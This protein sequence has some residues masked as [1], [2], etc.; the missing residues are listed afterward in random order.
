MSNQ[1]SDLKKALMSVIDGYKAAIDK[2]EAVIHKLEAL[3]KEAE[4]INSAPDAPTAEGLHLEGKILEKLISERDQYAQEVKTWSTKLEAAAKAYFDV[5][6][7]S[8][9]PQFYRAPHNQ[10]IREVYQLLF[11]PSLIYE[12]DNVPAGENL[13]SRLSSRLRPG[14][15][16]VIEWSGGKLVQEGIML[17]QY[18]RKLWYA[19]QNAIKIKFNIRD[20]MELRGLENITQTRS[21]IEQELIKLAKLRIY[22]KLGE[23]RRGYHAFVGTHLFEDGQV[24]LTLTQ[25]TIEM[26]QA[27]GNRFHTYL[28]GLFRLNLKI[29]PNS[30]NLGNWLCD[31]KSINW[32]YWEGKDA[33]FPTSDLLIAANIQETANPHKKERIARRIERDLDALCDLISWEYHPEG[34]R[35]W[36]GNYP[37]W[38]KAS[39]KVTYINNP[40]DNWDKEAK[41]KANQ[42]VCDKSSKQ[43]KNGKR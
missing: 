29:N 14:E 25:E 5:A 35:E 10:E 42:Q 26:F 22:R 43:K 28:D 32:P 39:I 4:N 7:F 38:K 9:V 8:S 6:G 33:I 18:I 31:Q 36:P 2:S 30:W 15:E 27:A 16:L 3:H 11:S 12:N 20:Y 13:E 19:D 41:R 24:I 37:S 17:P 1:K 23:T 34:G 21:I 40:Y